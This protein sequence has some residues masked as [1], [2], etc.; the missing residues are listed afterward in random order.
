M[1]RALGTNR[2]MSLLQQFCVDRNLDLHETVAKLGI[3]DIKSKQPVF[4]PLILATYVAEKLSASL[5][6]NILTHFLYDREKYNQAR[7]SGLLKELES[8]KELQSI[9]N[10]EP[11]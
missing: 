2:A 6:Y 1:K 10:P 8:Y 3:E 4:V 7:I 5:H 11:S 9:F